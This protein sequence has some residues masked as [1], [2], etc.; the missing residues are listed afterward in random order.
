MRDLLAGLPGLEAIG[1]WLGGLVVAGVVFVVLAL[2]KRLLI[3]RGKHVVAPIHGGA[4]RA[5]HRTL[6]GLVGKQRKPTGELP[7][8]LG[9]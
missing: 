9:R 7:V 8:D 3:G 2:A 1:P 6:S 5:M 4:Q